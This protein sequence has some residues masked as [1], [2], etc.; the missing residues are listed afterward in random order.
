MNTRPFEYET[1]V[2]IVGGGSAGVGA[3]AA[4]LAAGD[5]GISVLLVEGSRSLGGTST[6]GGVNCWEPGIGGPGIHAELYRRLSAI[7]GAAGVGKTTH[8]YARHEPYGLSEIDP[9]LTYDSTLARAGRG[10]REWS[11]AHFEPGAMSRTM[12]DLLRDRGGGRLGILYGT[13]C[14]GASVDGGSVRSV[15]CF[16]RT[17]QSP[18]VIK[19]A[20]FVDATAD[21]AVARS[22][23]CETAF[24]EDPVSS[25]GESAAPDAPSDAVN[26]ISLIFRV[27]RKAAGSP[28]PGWIR[29]TDALEWAASDPLTAASINIYPDGDLNVNVLPVMNGSEFFS[30]EESERLRVC[31][32]RAYAHWDRMRREYGFGG[33]AITWFAPAFGI[34][35]SYRLV[36]R[37]VLTQ[38]DIL[39]GI[40]RQRRRDELI[41]FADH[42]LDLH[43]NRN[44]KLA[45]AVELDHPY[46][47]PYSC[48]LPREISNLAVA[49]RGASFSHVAASSCRLSRTMM[50]VGEAAGA[51]AAIASGGSRRFGD[52]DPRELRRVLQ[53]PEFEERLE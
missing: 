28:L 37:H 41:A 32:A 23:G 45:G 21:I 34:R 30:M 47:I 46:G 12:E 8:F 9:G 13:V 7:P 17:D 14:T 6:N 27:S 2:C 18:V 1:D 36:G 4:A 52:V 22:A 49:C 33:F 35:E 44:A 29:E 11:R 31:R 40:G 20:I 5:P 3:A 16:R 39:A 50:A 42:A 24:G 15:T 53:I 43:G 38:D 19:A 51:A 10:S 26:G 48:L 25:Y